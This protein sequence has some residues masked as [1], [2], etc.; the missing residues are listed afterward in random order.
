VNNGTGANRAIP[1]GLGSKP[2]M[3]IIKPLIAN[4]EWLVYHQGS[5]SNDDLNAQFLKLNSGDGETAMPGSTSAATDYHFYTPNNNSYDL[6]TTDS[7][8]VIAYCWKDVPNVSKFGSYVGNASNNSVTVG[9]KPKFL[10]IK[11]SSEAS[12]TYGW[13][14]FNTTHQT[15][16]KATFSGGW[17]DTGT[18]WSGNYDIQIL[19]SGFKHR[20]NNT[21]LDAS[22]KTYL[23]MAWADV[24][25]KYNNGF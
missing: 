2:D 22:G 15:S 8:G 12:T 14:N 23:Y 4:S 3:I 25:A 20:N 9:F 24:P 10:I 7:A 5:T 17:F 1:H 16:N 19:G 11:K 18:A 21:N 6:N 13:A